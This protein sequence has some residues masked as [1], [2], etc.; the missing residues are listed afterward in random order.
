MSTK[1]FNQLKNLSETELQTK[2][3]EAEKEL[4][5]LKIK[6][7]TGQTNNFAGIWLRRKEIAR[8][9]TLLTAYAGKHAQSA[10]GGEKL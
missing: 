8:I 5:D 3:R 10:D 6:R 7:V 9:K 2:L 4:Y 1:R